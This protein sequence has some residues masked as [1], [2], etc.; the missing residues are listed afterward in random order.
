MSEEEL[1]A[2]FGEDGWYELEDEIY[3]R[4]SFTSMKVAIEEHHE[5]V[6]VTDGY[7]AYHT[8]KK[9]REDLKIAGCGAHARRC[10]D[11]AV[12]ALPKDKI[13]SSLAYLALKQIQ[14]IYR[15]DNKLADKSAE[16]RLTHRQLT[17]NPLVDVYFAWEKQNQQSVPAK[18]KTA[19]GLTYSL[20]QEKYL[21]T[22]LDDGEVPMDN[23]AAEQSIRPFCVGKKNWVKIDTVAGAEASAMIYSIAETAKANNLKLYN[24]FKYAALWI[25]Q[26]IERTQVNQRPTVYY[27][28]HKKEG[29]STIYPILKE[30]GYLDSYIRRESEIRRMIQDQLGYSIDQVED[31]INQLIPIESLDAI[32][33]MFLQNI[34]MDDDLEIVTEKEIPVN[35]LQGINVDA[36][37]WNDDVYREIEKRA[38][39]EILR[40]MMGELTNREQQILQ[41]RYGFEDGIEKTLEEV[42]KKFGVT[43]ERIRQIEVKAIAKLSTPKRRQKLQDFLY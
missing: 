17:V 32:Y 26:N 40:S 22:F 29:Y 28:V 2:E 9:E 31:I 38:L 5:G 12:K 30:K 19:N 23:N 18:S 20:N 4:Y 37:N 25:L 13:R 36:I 1:I 41:M 42:G 24:Y 35:V 8:L 14:A 11:E 15:E 3:R 34:E 16:E 6:C 10:F 7:Q 21:R 33:E 43:R 39:G 27:P